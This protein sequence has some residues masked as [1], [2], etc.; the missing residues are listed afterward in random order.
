MLDSVFLSVSSDG[1]R[2]YTYFLLGLQVWVIC[3]QHSRISECFIYITSALVRD[4]TAPPL[5][6]CHCKVPVEMSHWSRFFFLPL[7]H[8][9]MTLSSCFSPRIGGVDFIITRRLGSCQSSAQS[10]II[11]VS[12]PDAGVL[13]M[14]LFLYT[15]YLSL[16][17]KRAKI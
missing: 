8:L 16:K 15:L 14:S 9:N 6:Q 17:I 5:Q 4:S 2:T 3:T 1:Y 12:H 11:T 7:L 13:L 10:R